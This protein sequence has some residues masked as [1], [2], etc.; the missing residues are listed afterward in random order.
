MRQDKGIEEENP[1]E[2]GLLDMV[3]SVVSRSLLVKGI[4]SESSRWEEEASTLKSGEWED[5]MPAT[6]DNAE[7]CRDTVVNS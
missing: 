3:R 6:G 1:D 2:G 5:T 4:T 7:V